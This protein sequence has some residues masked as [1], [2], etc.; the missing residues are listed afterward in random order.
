MSYTVY[1]HTLK[2]IDVDGS[3]HCIKSVKEAGEKL[4]IRKTNIN[5]YLNGQ[6]K[7][8]SGRRWCY[9]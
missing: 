6:R 5:R 4:G 1:C 9:A 8:A 2:M 7:D 3:E